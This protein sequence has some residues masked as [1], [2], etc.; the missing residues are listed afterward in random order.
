[1]FPAEQ[2]DLPHAR[3]IASH[4]NLRHHVIEVPT[5]AAASQLDLASA[6]YDEPFADSSA[7]PSLALAAALGGRYKVILNGDGGDEAFAGYPHYEYIAAKQ[8]LKGAAASAGFAD[9]SGGVGVY[10]QSKAVF[11]S[12]E[13]AQLLSEHAPGSTLAE[14]LASDSY[15]RQAP[16]GALH[17]ALWS[18]RH[19]YLAN[20]LT[21][22]MDIALAA[23]GMEGR[24]PFLDHRILEWAQSLDSNDL[25]RGREKK[26]LLRE[27]YRDALPA[28]VLDRP[29]HGFGAPIAS[30]M[31]GPLRETI[32]ESLPCP[33]L[34]LKA[35]HL[36]AQKEAEGQRLWTLLTFARWAQRWGARW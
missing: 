14:L 29:K 22:K 18:D 6:H 13:R 19:L 35:Q 17:R 2:T 1:V 20:N 9:G 12:R 27:A 15:L 32:R 31:A 5:Q 25:V 34:D 36:Y 24:A 10:V 28:T 16:H 33:L 30:W 3:A 26:V 21:Y 7:L 8:A 23:F 4:L 11:R